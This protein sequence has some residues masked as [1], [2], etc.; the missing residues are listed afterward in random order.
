MPDESCCEQQGGQ[1]TAGQTGSKESF[2]II[3]RAILWGGGPLLLTWQDSRVL[4][5]VTLCL[6]SISG[7]VSDRS[8]TSRDP[9]SGWSPELGQCPE[10]APAL[11]G[12]PTQGTPSPPTSTSITS[13]AAPRGL[14][15]STQASRS[16]TSRPQHPCML[17]GRPLNVS[18]ITCRAYRTNVD[19]SLFKLRSKRRTQNRFLFLD[20]LPNQTPSS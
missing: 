12:A 13:T 15:P 18:P 17:P 11:Q 9:R 5:A 2:C 20:R 14:Y 10:V 6:R 19:L 8:K 4:A 3:Q 1:T 7:R 16:S